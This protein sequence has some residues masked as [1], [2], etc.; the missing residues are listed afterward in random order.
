MTVTDMNDF[1][2]FE[3]R[4]QGKTQEQLAY[5]L[6]FQRQSVV[7]RLSGKTQW[8][9]AEILKTLE[10]LGKEWKCVNMT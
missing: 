8:S 7:D 3:L 9:F 10:F 2:K 5:Y 4:K 6:D 1:I